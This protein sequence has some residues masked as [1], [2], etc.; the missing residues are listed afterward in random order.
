MKTFLAK[1]RNEKMRLEDREGVVMNGEDP[2]RQCR[3]WGRSSK[4][5]IQI[6]QHTLD[7]CRRMS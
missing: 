1:V 4:R 3:I 6:L 7:A 2:Q 5:L